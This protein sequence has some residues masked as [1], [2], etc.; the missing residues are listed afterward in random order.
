MITTSNLRLHGEFATVL[1]VAADG[2]MNKWDELAETWDCN[3]D[4]LT[5]NQRS[6]DEIQRRLTLTEA[7]VVLDF[8]CGTG[9]LTAKLKDL[10]GEVVGVDTAAKMVEHFKQKLP[11]VEVHAADFRQ[12]HPSMVAPSELPPGRSQWM[13]PGGEI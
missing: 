7:S 5:F 9:L 13:A 12:L 11:D 4:A 8:G 6:A 10:V 1:I 2:L 3:K